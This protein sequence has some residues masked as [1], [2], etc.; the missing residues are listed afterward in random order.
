M[1]MSASPTFVLVVAG[2]LFMALALLAP[3][4]RAAVPVPGSAATVP[5][6]ALADQPVPPPPEPALEWT[7]VLHPAAGHIDVDGRLAIVAALRALDEPWA[8]EILRR[9]AAGERD[10]QVRAAIDAATA[11]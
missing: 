1:R 10:P 2:V 7:H 11:A 5:A 3:A 6:A 9:A 4:S 8:G